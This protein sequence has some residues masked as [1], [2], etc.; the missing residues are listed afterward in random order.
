[1]VGI[2][3]AGRTGFNSEIWGDAEQMRQAFRRPVYSSV[4]L[5]LNESGRFEAMKQAL[6]N[7]PRMTIEAKRET[8]YYAEQSEVMA[9]FIRILGLVL[10]VIFSLGAVIGAMI[11]M[12]ASV[13]SRTQEIGTL[14]RPGVSP[15][16]AFSPRS[17]WRPCCSAAPGAR[18]AWCWL[19]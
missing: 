10:S 14:A 3:D 16:A 6:E 4:T 5:R 17:W 2:I 12:Y 18:L 11:T 13:A 1:V 7:D 19:R 8:V 15:A 9:K